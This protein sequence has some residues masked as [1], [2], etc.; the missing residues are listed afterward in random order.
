M[1]QLLYTVFI[2]SLFSCKESS[3]QFDQETSD[4]INTFYSDALEL[5]ESYELLR[6]LSKDIG[7]RPSGSEGAKKAVL[8][9]K[10]VMENYGFDS[11]YLQEVMVPHWERG[12][13]EEAY[14]Y[15]GKE[16][17][18]LSI[19]GAGGT[20]STPSEGITAK[21]IE[22]SSLD[23]VDELGRENIEGK[24]VL[25]LEVNNT[26]DISNLT[27]GIYSIRFRRKDFTETRNFVVK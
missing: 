1:R 10:E 18:N 27:S 7:P 23:E 9:S 15:E 26:I 25:S 16:K 21:V 20:V 14:F 5:R 11:V 4:V 22:V 24:I 17:I 8:W 13:V 3:T 2:F 12:D 6:V 19:L